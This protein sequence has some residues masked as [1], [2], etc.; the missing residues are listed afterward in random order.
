[1]LAPECI[2]TDNGKISDM[3]PMMIFLFVSL[4]F[5]IGGRKTSAVKQ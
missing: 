1:M 3:N 2:T 5:T 4:N